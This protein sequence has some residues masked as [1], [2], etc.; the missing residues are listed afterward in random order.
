ML[1]LNINFTVK[2]NTVIRSYI[3]EQEYF[4]QCTVKEY[5]C[6]GNPVAVNHVHGICSVEQSKKEETYKC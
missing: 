3:Q 2:V 1:N 4:L 5:I 6:M